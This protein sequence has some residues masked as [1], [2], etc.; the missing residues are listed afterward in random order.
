MRRWRVIVPLAVAA[1]LLCAVSTAEEIY[2]HF[3]GH[4]SGGQGT[5]EQYSQSLI[6]CQI[7]PGSLATLELTATVTPSGYPVTIEG[8]GLPPWVSF[9]PASGAG[10]VSAFATISPPES[11]VGYS[12]LLVFTATTAYE[13]QAV[14]EVE[15][16]ITEGVPIDGG[17][18]YPEVP[19]GEQTDRGI[20]FEIPFIKD[21][22]SFALG[23]VTDCVTHALIPPENLST[24]FVVPPGAEAPYDLTQLEKVIVRSPGYLPYEITDFRPVT[25]QILFL[26]I[27]ILEPAEKDICLVPVPEPVLT[28]VAPSG[29]CVGE[30]STS[31]GTPET[32]FRWASTGLFLS[33]DI[34]IYDNPCGRY[35][36]PPPP[37]PTPP[38]TAPTPT[39]GPTPPEGKP[40][41][42][43]AGVWEPLWDRLTP[44][45][46]EELA[47]RGLSGWDWVKAARELLEESGQEVPMEG[48]IEETAGVLLPD[49]ELIARF[50]PIDPAMTE[51]PLPIA[52]LLEEGQ[53]F[54]WQ[55]FGVALAPGSDEPI[56]VLSAPSC[57]RYQPIDVHTEL[58]VEPIPCIP[59]E[60]NI[61]VEVVDSPAMDGGL[62]PVSETMTI[63]RD[64]F[65]P[66]KAVGLDFDELWWYCEPCHHCPEEGSFRM[67]PLTGKV[68]FDW[69]I[70]QGE[71]DFVEIGCVSPVKQEVGD[72]VI[73]MPPYVEK[74]KTKTTSILLQIIDDNPSQPIDQTVKRW[75]TIQTKRDD[76][77]GNP[78]VYQI[79]ISS[80]AY[81][82][83]QAVQIT[84]EL[85]ECRAEPPDWKKPCK[86]L[87]AQILSPPD[88]IIAEKEWI[89]LEAVDL[90][91][92]DAVDLICT[93]VHC[94]PDGTS[95]SYNDDVRWTWSIVSGGGRFVKG[96]VGRFV[97]YE[98]PQEPTDVEIQVT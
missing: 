39:P 27:T 40:V 95:R 79:S 50:G 16:L 31:V 56:G 41:T 53:A 23:D 51:V 57:V 66:L 67:R 45:Q 78:D 4:L 10:T 22:T 12:V 5:C 81:T 80:S 89:R 92:P 54:I 64:D 18:E 17:P 48:R 49:T 8:W 44:E 26:Q 58:P 63:K 75:I 91:D 28:L 85:A 93:S 1:C 88:D 46:R 35:P 65:V 30:V 72:R 6:S 82:L 70:Q 24:E 21:I 33:Y 77:S 42:T 55:V 13:L 69:Q 9:A 86:D 62:D 71:G 73:F 38:P 43:T 47:R 60:C 7:P 20:E 3:S 74:G 11:A 52:A 98:A 25:F 96:N 61:R 37:T 68:R 32:I 34:L 15:L 76:D 97:I 83:P 19:G 90:Q 87:V 2:L 14:L 94:I 36:E 59:P 29:P 84:P